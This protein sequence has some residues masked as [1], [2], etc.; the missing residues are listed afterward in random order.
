MQV[1]KV[2]YFS[3]LIGLLC[4]I[5]FLGA[6]VF[7]SEAA[8]STVG[9]L[10]IAVVSFEDRSGSGLA[11]V[12][13]GVA[14]R[15]VGELVNQGFTVLERQELESIL[16]ERNLNP[17]ISDNLAQAGLI[18]GADALIGGA[19]TKI[20][21]SETRVS[22]GFIK[23]S[24]ATVTIEAS[25]RIISPYT[26]Q[27]MATGSVTAQD[28]GQT[29]F[30]LNIGRLTN[31]LT[32]ARTSVCTGG[33]LTDKNSYYQG[34]VINFGYRDFSPMN[35]FRVRIPS[36]GWVSSPSSSSLPAP[37]VTWTYSTPPLSPGTYTAR[38]Q[39]WVGGS[40]TTVL[41]RNFSINLGSA[42]PTWVN[43]ITVGTKQFADT[44]VGKVMDQA[45]N[46]M[47]EILSTKL[48]QVGPQLL[49]QREAYTGG[50]EKPSQEE[51]TEGLKCRVLNV[52]GNTIYIGN[53]GE[54]KACGQDAGV[55]VDD[56]FLVYTAK[57][58]VD[59]NTGQLIELVPLEDQPKGKIIVTNVYQNA[60][61][62]QK[63]GQFAIN[64]NDLAIRKEE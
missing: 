24:D 10:R 44:I 17:A 31:T 45:M 38:L 57:Q 55:K 5:F 7:Y 43:E 34:E 39:K 14:N 18:M 25:F 46:Q 63:I 41:S 1:K 21:I 56:I 22:L 20:N 27:I 32:Q 4:L 42:P 23:V 3:L 59:P 50:E 47:T 36:V 54:G 35:W 60:A 16:A 48:A 52:D 51:A 13:D 19:V 2:K 37:C 64:L 61:R 9:N 49:D 62:A 6:N 8:T 30:T 53:A 15:L 33:F 58:I 40:W 29:N 28:S 11:N 12:G 26:S